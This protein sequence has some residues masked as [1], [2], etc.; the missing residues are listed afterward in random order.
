M[1]IPDLT[2]GAKSAKVATRQGYA[3]SAA[4]KIP[5]P[6][7]QEDQIAGK[8]PPGIT[9]PAVHAPVRD[10]HL[11]NVDAD[12]DRRTHFGRGRRHGELA[13]VCPDFVPAWHCSWTLTP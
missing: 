7:A 11:L 12:T 10:V 5:S 13:L 8:A 6:D 9:P 1:H 4:V 2:G 3:D